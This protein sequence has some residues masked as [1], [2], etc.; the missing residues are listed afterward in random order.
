MG[1]KL[2]A[3]PDGQTNGAPSQT[4]ATPSSL[5]IGT[6][7]QSPSTKRKPSGAP[8]LDHSAKKPRWETPSTPGSQ[9]KPKTPKSVSFAAEPDF[10]PAP[11]TSG[12]KVPKKPKQKH[13]QDKAANEASKAA[14]P[15][16]GVKPL[17]KK[18]N[19]VANLQSAIDYLRQWHSSRDSWKFNKNHQTRLLEYVFTD[20]T[21]I[22]AVDINIFYE[23]IRPL[24]GYVRKRLRE[25]AEEVKQKDMEQGA[26]GF[27]TSKKD[28]A[29]RKQ[30]E[31][32]EVIAGFLNEGRTPEKRRFEEVEY[33]LRTA[34]M[35]MQRR[36]VKRMRAEMVLD[37]LSG[38][39]DSE[40]TT[41]SATVTETEPESP[42]GEA[43][44]DG[45][46]PV[47]EGD[48]RLKLNDGTQKRVR[49]R[50]ARTAE[51]DDSSSSSEAESDSDSDMSSSDSDSSDDSG[52]D[53][54]MQ[55]DA[56]RNEGETS[57][58]SSSSSSEAESGSEDE[59]SDDED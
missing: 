23:Y 33:V 26:E 4:T 49:K 38:S 32:E 55:V 2:K 53:D 19:A 13:S 46:V 35:E 3:A 34:D 16:S 25:T 42:G 59:S 9:T 7:R 14:K 30:K 58:S 57:S 10:S 22:P 6:D 8:A 41:S 12:T 51:V 40:T 1:L 5:A 27:S 28:A 56:A 39:E 11:A 21:T 20:E 54:A 43:S 17:V 31:Y 50:K 15:K 36:V 47:S 29:E 48:K 44:R 24:K 45:A 18:E 52:S 37:E